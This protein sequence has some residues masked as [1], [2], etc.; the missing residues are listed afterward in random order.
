MVKRPA[1][2]SV[3]SSKKALESLPPDAPG[4]MIRK[5]H[6]AH[7]SQLFPVP[8]SAVKKRKKGV[9]MSFDPWR[10]LTVPFLFE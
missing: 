1:N 5:S 7:A 6:R 3:S 2:S 9:S 4:A 8:L 10:S